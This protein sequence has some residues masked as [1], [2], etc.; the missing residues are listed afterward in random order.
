MTVKLSNV[1]EYFEFDDTDKDAIEAFLW[2]LKDSSHGIYVATTVQHNGTRG[3]LY[4]HRY[5][6][7]PAHD[8]DVHHKDQNPLNNHR[9]NLEIQKSLEHRK[10]HFQLAKCGRGVKKARD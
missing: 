8:E 6:M 3:T 2:R 5:L 1:D 10:K 7:S 9:E 4:L